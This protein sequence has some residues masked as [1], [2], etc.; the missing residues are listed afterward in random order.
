MRTLYFSKYSPYARKVRVLLAELG[1][2][3]SPRLINMEAAPSN[4]GTMNPN[5]RIPLFVDGTQTMF[6]SNVILDYLLQTYPSGPKADPPIASSLTRP[7]HHWKDMLVLSTIETVMDSGLNVFRFARV[8]IGPPQ[9]PFLGRELERIGSGLDWL[10]HRMDNEGFAPGTFSIMDMNLVILLQWA[11]F[12]KPFEW[13][14][15]P[16]LEALLERYASRPS[17]AETIPVE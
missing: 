13:R 1:L 6:E 15:R 10:E 2:E 11:D 3:Y 7:E 17:I 12:R 4:F 14:G 8:N 16:R 9:A 5:L